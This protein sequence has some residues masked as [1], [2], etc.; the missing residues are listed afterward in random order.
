MAVERAPVLH[1]PYTW[2]S[3]LFS[4]LGRD[5]EALP[6]FGRLATAH[7]ELALPW[8][9]KGVNEFELSRFDDALRSFERATELDPWDP[10]AYY[11]KGV[12]LQRQG[13]FRAAAVA[14][15]ESY[16][17]G[18]A[19]ETAKRLADIFRVTGNYDEA[20]QVV[21]V[22]LRDAPDSADLHH[23][24]GLLELRAEKTTAAESSLRRAIEL[25]PELVAAHRDLSRL[26]FR[27]G[28]E[29]E[30]RRAKALADRLVDYRRARREL[31]TRVATGRDP[32]D[33]M[34]LAEVELT[35]GRV[36]DALI[37][38][39]QALAEGAG[40]PRLLAGQAEA[41]FRAGDRAR[42]EQVLAQLQGQSGPRIELAR[43]TG[44]MAAGD[45]DQAL[46]ILDRALAEAPRERELLRR[47]ADVYRMAG[48]TAEAD[49]LLEQ[50]ATLPRLS[51]AELAP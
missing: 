16:G 2:V 22:G 13:D 14:L 9:Y 7:P 33:R 30:A 17:L 28:R 31:G 4:D 32:R 21:A 34:L 37:L 19:P 27:S 38:Y 25:D 44:L 26:L 5:E 41:L 29:E 11:R 51:A 47:A 8:F 42:G 50:S 18:P 48:R 43:A 1:Q 10:K 46:E 40:E 15:R 24:K 6:Y 3:R 12:V 23:A 20:E 35:G 39:S 49:R 45:P 36:R